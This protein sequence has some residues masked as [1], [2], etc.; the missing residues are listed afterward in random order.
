[1]ASRLLT[2]QKQGT[3]ALGNG[4]LETA[5]F[6]QRDAVVQQRLLR[7]WMVATRLGSADQPREVARLEGDDGEQV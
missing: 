4:L 2:A 7:V 3:V 5:E 1:M 6:A